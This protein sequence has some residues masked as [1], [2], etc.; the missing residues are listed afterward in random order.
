[1]LE[2]GSDPDPVVSGDVETLKLEVLRL[3]DTL[4]GNEA[5]IGELT[6]RL[7]RLDE[8]RR[9]SEQMW[10]ERLEHTQRQLTA[11][12]DR[13][14]SIEASTSWRIGQFVLRP[15]HLWRRAAGRDR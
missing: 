9:I 5:H 15:V 3:R 10:T 1:M 14:A 11:A 2:G 6:A 4:R 7:S 12:Q 8:H 13:A